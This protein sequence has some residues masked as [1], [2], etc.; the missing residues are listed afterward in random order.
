MGAKAVSLRYMLQK[1]QCGVQEAISTSSSS[2]TVALTRGVEAY[3]R[4]LTTVISLTGAAMAPTLNPA[5]LSSDKGGLVD[6]L[7]LRSIPRPTH[8]SVFVGDVV[9]FH[10]PLAPVTEQNVLVRR[11]GA[12]P[13]D[14]LVTDDP[15]AESYTIPAGHCWVLADNEELQPPPIDSRSF[16]PLPLQNVLGRIMYF[17]RSQTD[18]GVVDNS[19]EA[20]ASD[21]AVLEAELDLNK[22]RGDSDAGSKTE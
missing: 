17:Y 16:G 21:E 8:R 4:E 22:L 7:L 13:G 6:R 3:R 11:I 19:S 12:G 5:A 14:E 10:S 2:L 18:Y 15:E 9:A 20:A 1:F